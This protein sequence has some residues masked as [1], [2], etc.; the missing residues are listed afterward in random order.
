MTVAESENARPPIHI[1]A[2]AELVEATRYL[3]GFAPVESIVLIGSGCDNPALE[4]RSVRLSAR[5]DL[6]TPE[7]QLFQVVPPLKRGDVSAVTVLFFTAEPKGKGLRQLSYTLTDLFLAAGI[8]LTD[9]LVA[10]DTHWWSMLCENPQCCPVGGTPRL[11]ASHAAAE[12]VFAGIPAAASREALAEMFEPEPDLDRYT[13]ALTDAEYR[14]HQAVLTK[15]LTDLLKHDL[16]LILAELRRHHDDPDRRLTVPQVGRIAVA[17]RD[18][19]VRDEIWLGIDE[20]SIEADD[21]MLQLVRRLPA[22]YNASPL[23]L[24]GWSAWRRGN[25]ALAALAAEKAMQ[26]DPNYSAAHLLLAATQHGTDPRRIPKLR[27][28]E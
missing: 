13:D 28:P 5:V 20:R 11:T 2:P 7:E 9:V 14:I 12:M 18:Q 22:P 25:G 23:F 4:R 19:A 16:D 24:Y 26:A 10:T 17:L 27:L 3:L 21:L 15:R 6:D 1:S 8:E